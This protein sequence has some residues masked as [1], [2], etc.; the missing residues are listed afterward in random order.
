MDEAVSTPLTAIDRI[1]DGEGLQMMKAAIPYLP[2]ALQKTFS[3]YVK[4]LEMNN[5]LS[6]YNR[7]V[8]ACGVQGTDAD[9]ILSDIR[10]YCTDSQLKSLD[11]A[12]GLINTLKMY[13][14]IQ[15]LS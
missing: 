4:V 9:E 6:Y 2:G 8:H 12:V 3:L 7:P 13:Q 15:K 1:A 11:Q 5:L 10:P 14:E